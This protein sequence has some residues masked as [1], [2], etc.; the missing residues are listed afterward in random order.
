MALGKCSR[1]AF[2]SITAMTAAALALDL[3]KIEAW[4]A[5]M[6]DKRRYPTVII[7]AGLGGLCC[8]AY[9]AKSGIPVT[10]IEQHNIPGG[11]ATSFDRAQ[12][13]FT[14]EVSLHGT[15]IHQ[16]APARILDNLGLLKRLELVEL[17]ETYRL[18][19]PNSDISVPQRDPQGYIRL[20]GEHFPAE[21]AG[22]GRFV[23]NMIALAEETDRLHQKQGK[24]VKLLFPL[25]YRRMWNVRNKTLADLIDADIKD[26]ELKNL[27][28]GLWAY[29]G[30]P[31]SRLSGF[32]YANATGG[33]LKDGSY[34]IKPRSQNLSDALAAVIEENGGKI[35]YNTRVE[36]IRLQNGAV[37]GV[38]AS[39]GDVIEAKAVVSNASATATLCEM[40]PAN[41]L[42]AAYLQKIQ[43]LRPSLS[44]FI[45]WLGLNRELR[46][47]IKGSGIY[48]SS[49]R[50]PEADYVS[51][52]KGEI[53]KGN[54]GIAL[55]DNIFEG[56]SRAGT[57]TL[58]LTF[59]SGY[60]S[61]RPF[62]ADYHAGRKQAYQK[63]KQAWTDTLVR[64]AQE[65]VIPGLCDMIEVSEAATPLTNRSFTGN[66]EGAIYG[67][68]Q[69]LDNA[70]MN[71]IENRT[72]VKGLYLASAWSN[73]GGGYG[74]VL[75]A[76]EK[77]F[78]EMMQDWGG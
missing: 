20:L 62:E 70:F 73:P 13:K 50:G 64:R 71:R 31:P 26:P 56:Y 6:G 29:Y 63:Q 15:S 18:I 32:Y 11:Y 51:C 77:A 74:G 5:K 78:Q 61:W 44:T 27:M 55:Y 53:D 35:I 34:Y 4:A 48:V 43:R 76:G 16:N 25:T 66:F 36:N 24:F 42:P 39:S 54:F 68:E 75:R 67:F 22:I 21:R 57:S 46:G 45:V 7:G 12:G 10:L 8:G 38:V 65:K 3:K 37:A 9:L 23:E 17:P 1:R 69:S 14:F 72:P 2:L 28:A 33:Y 40:L 47:K 59:L 60:D 41:A 30:L 52:L 19:T 49:G 58:M